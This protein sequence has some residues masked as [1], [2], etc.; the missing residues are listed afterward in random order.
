MVF[1]KTKWSL[2]MADSVTQRFS[3]RAEHYAKYR[4]LYPASLLKLLEK[5]IGFTEEWVIADIGS[6]TGISTAV[7]LKNE[8]TVYAIEPNEAM[9]EIA[10]RNLAAYSGFISV[11]ARA[12]AS[13]LEK[14]TI[15]LVVAA[16]AFHWFDQN[17]FKEEIKRI[18]RSGAYLLLLWNDRR[19]SGD[20]FLE[21]YEKFL[22]QFGTDYQKVNHKNT[23]QKGFDNFF[24]QGFEEIQLENRQAL[25]CEGLEGRVLSSSYVPAEGTEAAKEM[26]IVLK[27]L[28]DRHKKEGQVSIVYDTRL[29]FGKIK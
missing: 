24:H 7:F 13:T 8:N 29:Y 20:L 23:Q 10:E 21:E 15:D 14:N 1:K 12:E 11:D 17:K 5:E 9:R 25:S 6:G 28:F 19:V 3:G 26:L 2:L 4:P 16:Q 27:E 22:I 18:A